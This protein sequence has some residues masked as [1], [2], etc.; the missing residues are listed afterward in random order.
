MKFN[1][2]KC[3]ILHIGKDNPK[4]N[5][6]MGHTP[7]QV[8]EKERDLGVIVSAGDTLCWEEQ[9][10]GMIGKAKQM[11]S[12]IIGNVLSRKPEVLIPFCKAFVGH[13]LEHAVQVWVP[14]ARHGNWG[15]IMEIE[16]YQR[17]FTRIIEGMGP[18][19]YH[20]R[21]QH[22]RLTTLLERRMHSDLIKTFKIINGFVNYGHITFGTNTAYRTRN[23]NVTS[24]HPLRSAPDFSNNRVIKYWKQLLLRVQNSTSINAF[25]AGFDLFKL[26]KPD[27][28]NGF[29]KLS[30][31]IFNGIRDKSEHV[32]YLLANRDVA[33]QQN[34][35]F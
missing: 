8:V 11:T 21:L 22:L 26:S 16:D 25:K 32:N 4:N 28:P 24:H 6:M 3:R 9:I 1:E 17:Q 12:W 18:L 2:S 19:S 30:E 34:I 5:Y 33:M 10:Q 27:S 29:W 31:E 15:I 35:L 20:L 7:L 13:H 23:F 14:T